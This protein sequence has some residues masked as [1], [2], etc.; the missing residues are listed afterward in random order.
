MLSTPF[1]INLSNT[2]D[3]SPSSMLF[4]AS[5][6]ALGIIMIVI[7]V[8]MDRKG[9]GLKD[10]DCITFNKYLPGTIPVYEIP[11]DLNILQIQ[12]FIKGKPSVVAINAQIIQ[13]AIQ[14]YLTI[15]KDGENITIKKTLKSTADL[16][17]ELISFYNIIFHG[18]ET[19]TN[20]KKLFNY[21]DKTI[22]GAVTSD[23]KTLFENILSGDQNQDYF[24]I[25]QTHL[26]IIRFVLAM[27]IVIPFLIP[28]LISTHANYFILQ[29][30]IIIIISISIE[31][32]WQKIRLSFLTKAGY[33]YLQQIQGIYM[34]L[35][36]AEKDRESFANHPD[37]YKGDFTNL[38]PF[39]VLFGMEE[40]WN[41]IMPFQ[42]TD[43]DIDLGGR[44]D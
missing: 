9:I 10:R 28:S 4:F 13:L 1:I 20:K 26:Q 18:H 3:Q 30:I 12:S 17:T 42:A 27:V 19:V 44:G 7:A 34:Y 2:L 23:L 29:L 5:A 40:K 14:G 31:F 41:T 37:T 25:T 6:I 11:K 21:E 8:F 35:Q 15:S 43:I 24:K 32:L 33:D 22:L 16:S 39:I 36:T 38:L